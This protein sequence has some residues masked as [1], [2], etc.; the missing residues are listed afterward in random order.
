MLIIAYGQK[1]T[2]T[3]TSAITSTKTI[4][5]AEQ[6]LAILIDK[7]LL[8]REWIESILLIE[9]DKVREKFSLSNKDWA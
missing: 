6:A 4:E 3:F 9:G 7:G 2:E 5:T 1:E 8:Y